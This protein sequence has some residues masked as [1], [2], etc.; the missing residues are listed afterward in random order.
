MPTTIIRGNVAPYALPARP[1]PVGTS[2]SPVVDLRRSSAQLPTAGG[3]A[4]DGAGLAYL[5]RAAGAG[6]D[7]A[8]PV[9]CETIKPFNRQRG[10]GQQQLER[11]LAVLNDGHPV[12]FYGWW[13]TA[14]MA[15][16]NPTPGA[17]A[18]EV[19][20]PDRKGTA[21]VDGHAVVIVGYGRHGALPGGG[22]L[23]VHNS[24]SRSGWGDEFGDG[25]MPF[26]FLRACAT[27]L[28]TSRGEGAVRHDI[29]R[30][31]ER[32]R[33]FAGGAPA[34]ACRAA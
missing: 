4:W 29:A 2:A 20:P 8:P 22:C 31:S 5:Q 18:M 11:V 3:S 12:A 24:W 26:A 17:D 14:T 1:L 33:V 27:E 23:I 28:C 30:P 15:A 21:L 13:P 32:V 9:S 16:T 34:A 19:P 7:V 10:A 6:A 25:A